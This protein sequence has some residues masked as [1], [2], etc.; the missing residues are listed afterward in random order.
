MGLLSEI[1]YEY[2]YESAGT[3]KSS[4]SGDI[5]QNWPVLYFLCFGF[6]GDTAFIIA[7]LPEDDDGWDT[8]LKFLAGDC[9]TDVLEVLQ[10]MVDVGKVLADKA[11]DTS[12][13]WDGLV[14]ASGILVAGIRTFYSNI[15][16]K[17]NS[18]QGNFFSKDVVNV[19]LHDLD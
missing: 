4:Y 3:K 1:L 5:L 2:L 16:N 8:Q 18:E 17:W 19:S 12:I 7:P 10:D 13:F 15:I 11:A 14:S 9:A 6:M